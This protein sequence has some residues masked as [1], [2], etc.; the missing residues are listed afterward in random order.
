MISILSSQNNS[1]YNLM[2]INDYQ[3]SI[4]TFEN[5]ADAYFSIDFLINKKTVGYLNNLSMKESYYKNKLNFMEEIKEKVTAGILIAPKVDLFF[6]NRTGIGYKTWKSYHYSL[7]VGFDSEN[8]EYQALEDD[9]NSNFGM[10]SEKKEELEK[11]ILSVQGWE[12]NSADYVEIS[13][14]N[15][16]Q[17][18]H[19]K[20]EDLIVNIELTCTSIVDILKTDFFV[21][22]KDLDQIP[23]CTEFQAISIAKVITK[24]KVNRILLQKLL[25]LKIITISMFEKNDVIFEEI[26]KS[27]IIIKNVLLKSKFISVMEF[28]DKKASKLNIR[29]KENLTKEYCLWNELKDGIL[30]MNGT[31]DRLL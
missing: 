18:Y 26:C 10:I 22:T 2:Y 15:E 30:K 1:Y 9:K 8:S 3:Y 5:N 21:F 25:N 24:M 29:I 19:F 12:N 13:I 27:Y 23:E 11:A 4:H 20:V 31:K 6:W 17:D 28:R 14:N 7:L 16:L